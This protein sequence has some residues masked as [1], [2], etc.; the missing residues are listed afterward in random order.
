MCPPDNSVRGPNRRPAEN[1]PLRP[2]AG[3]GGWAAGRSPPP[4]PT[5]PIR[6][7]R[8]PRTLGS[9]H[10]SYRRCVRPARADNSVRRGTAGRPRPSAKR[11]ADR[12]APAGRWTSHYFI[13]RT[14]DCRRTRASLS[15]P[16]R[17]KSS[18][19]KPSPYQPKPDRA[20][21][22]QI[23]P[24]L[25]VYGK[26]RRG[27]PL[28]VD[29]SEPTARTLPYS[30]WP[31]AAM[32]FASIRNR[33][34]AQTAGRRQGYFSS[35]AERTYRHCATPAASSASPGYPPVVRTEVMPDWR[36]LVAGTRFNLR[37]TAECNCAHRG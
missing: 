21:L 8:R 20:S 29:R 19:K 17:A 23:V 27:V 32:L 11:A 26:R 37:R 2:A 25:S 4:G 24:G 30:R 34:I 33:I 14:S 28:A 5:S 10:L 18:R 16:R 6:S 31:G 1:G 35:S 22:S 3:A 36:N 7:A 9:E 12:R 15:R 13:R